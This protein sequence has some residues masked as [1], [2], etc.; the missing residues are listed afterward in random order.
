MSSS[1][2]QMVSGPC[3]QNMPDNDGRFK[4]PVCGP[5][6]PGGSN[7]VGIVYITLDPRAQQETRKCGPFWPRRAPRSH[8]KGPDT[9]YWKATLDDCRRVAAQVH[10]DTITDAVRPVL[11]LRPAVL[12]CR[13]VLIVSDSRRRR[14]QLSNGEAVIVGQVSDNIGQSI[15]ASF[16]S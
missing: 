5:A 9:P 15:L 12:N 10:C 16:R 2:L 14:F 1:P 7:A 3:P 4:A 11:M 13:D 8:Q 6:I